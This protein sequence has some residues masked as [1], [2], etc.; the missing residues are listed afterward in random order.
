MTNHFSSILNTLWT[1]MCPNLEYNRLHVKKSC[2][3]LP[4]FCPIQFYLYGYNTWSCVITW[5]R[6]G[7]TLFFLS[8]ASSVF[9]TNTNKKKKSLWTE[10]Q[11]RLSSYFSAS[12]AELSAYLFKISRV[13]FSREW[14]C[15]EAEIQRKNGSCTHRWKSLKGGEPRGNR[16]NCQLVTAA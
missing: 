6:P 9:S 2:C 13:R 11:R 5:W 4:P 16:R 15:C 8:E 3:Y 7:F 14:C 12:P 1:P 10:G